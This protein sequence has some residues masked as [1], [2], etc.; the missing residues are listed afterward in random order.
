MSEQSD[1]QEPVEYIQED[2]PSIKFFIKGNK[3]EWK[4]S[5]CMEADSDHLERVEKDGRI[6]YVA[7]KFIAEGSALHVG[8]P[9]WMFAMEDEY[10]KKSHVLLSDCLK[11]LS[12]SEM[13]KLILEET[14]LKELEPRSP[15]AEM[16]IK[17]KD[18]TESGIPVEIGADMVHI[19]YKILNNMIQRGN[20]LF[21]YYRSSAFS[22]SCKPNAG[23]LVDEKGIRNIFA[24][25]NIQCGEEISVSYLGHNWNVNETK[26]REAMLTINNS[27]CNCTLC[28]R[29]IKKIRKKKINVKQKSG[30]SIK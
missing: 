7:A 15:K 22:H 29:T 1:T 4:K 11:I 18:D 2:Y 5:F 13:W 23:E 12:T 8:L 30:I 19:Y 6:R 26:Q 9:F 16:L 24:I 10:P 17:L 20:R 21:V 3:V 28:T 25:K 27:I 14:C